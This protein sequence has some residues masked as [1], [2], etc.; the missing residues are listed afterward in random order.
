MNLDEFEKEHWKYFLILE[1]DFLY[2]ERYITIHD[3]NGQAFSVEY[4][5]QYQSVCSE[6]DVIAKSYCRFLDSNFN[7]DNIN[8][9]ASKI[10]SVKQ[11]FSTKQIKVKSRY[12]ALIIPWQ[13]WTNQQSPNWWKDYNKVKHHRNELNTNGLP[14]YML[15]NQKNL[16]CSL[17]ALFQLEMYFYKDLARSE[18]KD[19]EIP[20][21]SSHLFEIINWD[22]NVVVNDMVF[23]IDNGVLSVTTGD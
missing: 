19:I 2:T 1:C 17:A 5:K 22:D 6:I 20:L 7:G 11:D 3:N 13:N 23:R 12:S 16:I 4:A 10:M 15:A 9:Y 14:N 8:S 18:Q 21:P